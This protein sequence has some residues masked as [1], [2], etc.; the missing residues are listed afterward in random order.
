MIVLMAGLPGTGKTTVARELA[1]RLAGSVLSKD[2]IR[3]ALFEPRDVEYSTEQDDF[4]MEVMLQAAAFLAR[5][6]A[7][8]HVFLDGRVFSRQYQIERVIAAAQEINQP[9]M[10]LE[11]VCAE[12]TARQRLQSQ[13]GQHPA[14]NRNF[15]L[16]CEVKARFEPITRE[17]TVIDTDR[18]LNECI[19]LAL[20]SLL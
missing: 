18:P 17:K 9:W 1:S 13:A 2:A 7:G 16:Y 14:Q 15:Q 8:R 6:D 11:C 3:H 5:R 19:E 4:C 20:A 10:I 12:E